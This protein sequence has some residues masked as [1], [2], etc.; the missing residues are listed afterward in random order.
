METATEKVLR[1]L[2]THP[3]ARWE[4]KELALAA[5]CSRPFLSKLTKKLQETGIISR[6]DRKL[7]LISLPKLL[8]YWVSMRKLPSPIY[9]AKNGKTLEKIRN[10]KDYCLTL[11]SAANFRVVLIKTEKIDMYFYG[12]IKT[13][14][15]TFGKPSKHPTN[16]AVFLSESYIEIGS[17]NIDGFN[18]VS[19]YQNYVDLMTLG[20]TGVR[21]AVA[22]D[23][24]YNIM[25]V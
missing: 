22:L 3:K 1:L 8:S 10:L 11:F 14:Y 18:L 24:K 20:G 12:N 25:G 9:F 16:F 4:Q 17:E 15:K 2:A 13:L 7:V 21:V 6:L 23:R 19:I 5:K